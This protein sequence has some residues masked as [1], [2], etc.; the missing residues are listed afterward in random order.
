MRKKDMSALSGIV[1]LP[2][3]ADHFAALGSPSVP[4]FDRSGGTTG[5]ARGVPTLRV[6]QRRVQ[7]RRTSGGDAIGALR[8]S[9][10]HRE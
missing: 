3:A 10:R 6:R 8:L 2:N 5:P 9:R 7:A 4:A 1:K